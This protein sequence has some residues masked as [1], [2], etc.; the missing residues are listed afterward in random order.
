MR[1]GVIGLGSMGR[2]HARILDDMRDVELVGV[3]DPLPDVLNAVVHDTH[4]AGFSRADQLLALE[5]DAVSVCVPTLA[6]ME[7]GLQAIERGVPVLIEKPLA[8]TVEEGEA[9]LQASER[10]GVPVMVGHVERFNPVTWR[11]KEALGQDEVISIQLVRVGPFQPRIQDVGVIT[12]LASHDIDLIRFITNSEFD[13]VHAV[14]SQSLVGHEDT[15]LIVARMRNGVLAQITTNWLTPYK[16]RQ[17]TVASKTRYVEGDLI[18]QQI[19]EYSQYSADDQTYQVR[20]WPL[21]HREPVKEEI[22]GFLKA[23]EN[24]EEM[25]VTVADGL[26][27]LRIIEH[28][29]DAD[30]ITVSRR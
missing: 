11:I 2:I 29:I 16:S 19:R 23:L 28:I 8:R 21:I 9:L 24:E 26:E 6:H 10:S 17:I 7:V 1:V 20:E 5:L 25:P 14:S 30:P 22:I 12:D 3:A 18:S 15:A 4:I 27:V 13:E